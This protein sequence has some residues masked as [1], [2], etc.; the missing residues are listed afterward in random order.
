MLA[1][2]TQDLPHLTSMLCPV[3]HASPSL[4]LIER[5]QW[6]MLFWFKPCY[7]LITTWKR[8]AL[9]LKVA[10]SNP[11]N[12][13]ITNVYYPWQRFCILCSPTLLKIEEL[14]E[15]WYYPMVPLSLIKNVLLGA[16][17]LFNKL[18]H[19]RGRYKNTVNDLFRKITKIFYLTCLRG[20]CTRDQFRAYLWIF[21]ENYNTL[22][23]SKICFL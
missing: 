22:V 4:H 2:K 17:L 20:Y 10:G 16:G 14:E 6:Y 13:N 21:L 15:Y 3:S 18:A 5:R 11:G 9:N 1:I 19:L 7:K 23:T 8:S 12:I